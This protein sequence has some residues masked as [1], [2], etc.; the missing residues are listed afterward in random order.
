MNKTTLKQITRAIEYR[1]ID[2]R[3]A[4]ATCAAIHRAASKRDQR[5]IEALMRLNCLLPQ[6]ATVLPNGC[7]VET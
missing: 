1:G 5:D 6:H 4:A 7:I 2:P 3:F